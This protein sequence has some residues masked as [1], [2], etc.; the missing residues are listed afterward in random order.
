[1]QPSSCRMPR[2]KNMRKSGTA[3]VILTL[4]RCINISMTD[5]MKTSW[6][7]FFFIRRRI[8]LSARKLERPFTARA[9]EKRKTSVISSRDMKMTFFMLRRIISKNTRI[10]PIN[11]FRNP[12]MSRWIRSGTNV[13]WRILPKIR[14]S[15]IRAA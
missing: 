6:R 13:R 2:S 11:Y 8:P 15:D 12:I 10:F 7:V 14:R 1:M 4:P 5:F 9:R 3:Y